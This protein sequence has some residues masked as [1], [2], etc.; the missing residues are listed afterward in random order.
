[1]ILLQLKKNIEAIN[2]VL[3]LKIDRTNPEE[4]MGKL[5]ELASI[6]SLSATTVALAESSYNEK[7][8]Q[9]A[10]DYST[11][12]ISATDRK[13]IFQGKAKD[14]IYY[15]TLSERQNKAITHACDS[16]RSIL[17]FVKEEMRNNN[18]QP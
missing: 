8:G 15:M 9:L 14:E 2:Q 4:V 12:G 6:L 3:D 11:A 17:S 7:I 13:M 18:Y 5:N 10:D 16:L 1:M